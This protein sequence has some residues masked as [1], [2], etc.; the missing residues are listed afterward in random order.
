MNNIKMKKEI[1]RCVIGARCLVLLAGIALLLG[2]VMLVTTYPAAVG[3]GLFVYMM[4]KGI[5]LFS[6][7]QLHRWRALNTLEKKKL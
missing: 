1:K 7:W 3:A 5:L 6:D 4:G 2:V